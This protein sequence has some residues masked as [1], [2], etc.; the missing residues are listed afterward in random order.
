MSR[1]LTEKEIFDIGEKVFEE[2]KAIIEDIASQSD[3]M[4]VAFPY[5]VPNTSYIEVIGDIFCIAPL[6][7]K[8]LQDYQKQNK[9]DKRMLWLKNAW[10]PILVSIAT[11]L[12]I[13]G[14]RQLLP[15]IQEW[16]SSFL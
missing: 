6:G 2:M 4:P 14:M 10:I 7:K 3:T 1:D 16:V 12:I 9:V 5:S 15:L 11:N 13:D 8:A